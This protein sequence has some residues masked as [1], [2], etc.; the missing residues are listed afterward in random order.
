MLNFSKFQT[1]LIYFIF[2][3]FSLF[4]LL[5]FQSK[6]KIILDKKVNL[7]LD[8]QGG[9]YLLLEIDTKPLIKEKIQNYVDGY[10][11]L[12]AHLNSE[13]ALTESTGE[14]GVLFANFTVQNLQQPLRETITDQVIGVTGDFNYL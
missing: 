1:F 5:N 2:V 7:G 11:E 14:T 13:L 10:N 8:L 4:A 9:S 12:M 3:L 6:D